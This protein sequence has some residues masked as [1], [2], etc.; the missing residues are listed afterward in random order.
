M[1]S[2]PFV[3]IIIPTARGGEVLAKCLDSLEKQTYPKELFEVILISEHTKL[4][5]KEDAR[6]KILYGIDYANSRNKGAELAQGELLAFVDDDCIMPEDWMAKAVRYFD[7]AEVAVVGGPALPFKQDDF[8]WRVGGYLL[9][10]PFAC[11]F[12]SSRYTLSEKSYEAQEYNLLTANNFVRK[13]TF[14][15]VSGFDAAQELS[16]ENDLYFRMKQRG[17][18]LLHVPEIFVWH[19]AKA[20]ARP[21]L[22]SIFFYAT[23]RGVLMMRKPKSIKIIYLIPTLSVV[24]G[25]ALLI[26]AFFELRFLSALLMLTLLYGILDILNS[27]LIFLKH[28]KNLFV[29]L[30]VFFMTPLIHIVYGLG[31][32]YGVW[33]FATGNI[34]QGRALWHSN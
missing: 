1:K 34:S 10:S 30:S 17:Y 20:I 26:L 23:G 28:E 6:L 24:L 7:D 15:S 32:L 5:L 31:I 13:D 16:E 29:V 2:Q 9:A 21:I 14:N 33:L 25:M 12:A 18:K 27:M 4:S 19:R 22:Q 8:R 3:S 11:G